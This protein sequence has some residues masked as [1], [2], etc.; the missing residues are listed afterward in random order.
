MRAQSSFRGTT[1]FIS[2]RNCSLLVGFLY[3]SK[4]TAL[5]RLFM[6]DQLPQRVVWSYRRLEWTNQGCHNHTLLGQGPFPEDFFRDCFTEGF[7]SHPPKKTAIGSL[8]SGWNVVR[9]SDV[10]NVA[11]GIT[12]NSKRSVLPLKKPYLRVANVQRDSFNLN[13]ANLIGWTE[14]EAEQYRLKQGDIL[15]LE[16]HAD[17]NKIGRASL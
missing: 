15:V 5:A 14:K 2:A 1:C 6:R 10:A 4:V 11:Y 9:L 3:F 7:G 13:D 8:H 12:L 16:E 17:V